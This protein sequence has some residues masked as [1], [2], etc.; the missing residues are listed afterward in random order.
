M[1]PEK[2]P[3][4]HSLDNGLTLELWDHSRPV[5]GDRWQ[6]SLEARITIAVEEANLPPE[7]APQAA[8]AAAP[9]LLKEM[10]TRALDLA[11]RYFGH[12]DFARRLIRL[13]YARH[14]ERLRWCGF[15]GGGAGSGN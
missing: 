2:L 15:A 5:A 1:H 7:L 6:L 11:A 4:R 8:A 10:A 14:L 12:A 9:V 3:S 13:R